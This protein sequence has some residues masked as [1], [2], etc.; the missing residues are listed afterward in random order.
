MGSFYSEGCRDGALH[1]NPGNDGF[2]KIVRG[3]YVDKT[4]L[5]SLF[6]ST[7]NKPKG[8]VMVS[9]PRFVPMSKTEA[10]SEGI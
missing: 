8:L 10:W 2:A 9:S 6:D 7:L 1:V 3:E 4:G 5:V